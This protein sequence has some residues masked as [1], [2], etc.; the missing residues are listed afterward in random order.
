MQRLKSF[1]FYAIEKNMPVPPQLIGPYA[2]M[3]LQTTQVGGP[4]LV[5][6]SV[7]IKPAHMGARLKYVGTAQQRKYIC[8]SLAEG[9]RVWR[10][11]YLRFHCAGVV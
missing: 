8:C 2:D 4:F 5:L 11:Q 10:T 6:L 9:L 1:T 3:P 7:A